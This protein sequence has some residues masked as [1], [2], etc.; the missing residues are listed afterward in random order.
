MI[1]D[2][3]RKRISAP[4]AAA[5]IVVLLVVQASVLYL[6]G[7]IPICACGFVKLWHGAINSSQDS[8]HMTDWYTFSHI[9]H[10]FL[11]YFALR[12]LAPKMPVR[13]RIIIAA[14]IEIVWEFTENSSFIINRYRSETASLGYTGDSIINSVSDTLSMLTGFIL[15]Y[16][17]PVWLIVCVAI[18]FELF[19]LY[20]IR[21]N[22][23]LNVVMLVY[24]IEAIK[25]WQLAM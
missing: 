16:K 23:T 18:F 12:Y 14:L 24:P 3:L 5:I 15:A 6:M 25:H 13:L 17:F 8:Q 7:R 22:L 10:G 20:F 19:T 11:F 2:T 4:K 21:D 9:I 1:A